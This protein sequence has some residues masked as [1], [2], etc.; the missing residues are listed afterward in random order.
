MVLRRGSTEFFG[1][2]VQSHDETE[3]KE[4]K[5]NF[6]R[7]ALAQF[8][9]FCHLALF[10]LG[11]FRLV[12]PN[13]RRALWAALP[14]LG[15]TLSARSGVLYATLV[16]AFFLSATLIFLSIHP[17][18]PR[19]LQRLSCFLLIWT[20][21]IIGG[22]IFSLSPLILVSLSI[23]PPADFFRQRKHENRLAKKLFLLAFSFAALVAGHG[24]FSDLLGRQIGLKIFQ[25]PAGSYFFMGLVLPF[26]RKK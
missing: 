11:V 24:I 18:F 2:A 13:F 19:A 7:I 12:N 10:C 1:L 8:F 23:L 17:L 22:H 21:G 14:L 4:K 6:G 3:K 9:N 5:F 25:L 20:L 26:V 15:L 16:A